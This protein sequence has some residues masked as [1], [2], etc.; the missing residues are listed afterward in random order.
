MAMGERG[1]TARAKPLTHLR[2]HTGFLGMASSCE[3][4]ERAPFVGFVSA[5]RKRERE[6]RFIAHRCVGSFVRPSVRS[7]ARSLALLPAVAV[8][9]PRKKGSSVVE[10]GEFATPR[11]RHSL[12]WRFPL[13]DYP[14]F[15]FAT[16]YCH[17]DCGSVNWKSHSLSLANQYSRWRPIDHTTKSSLVV[18]SLV[19]ICSDFRLHLPS[20]ILNIF[21]FD[22]LVECH[23]DYVSQ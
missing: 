23:D 13:L 17:R 5:Q 6:E 7:L 14:G 15:A 3:D 10:N 18:P 11:S 12:T 2:R 16:V 20:S 1:A 4:A 22:S 21:I 8:G 9:L 19:I